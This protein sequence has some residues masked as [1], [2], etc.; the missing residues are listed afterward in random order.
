MPI[1]I[2][3]EDVIELLTVEESIASVEEAFRLHGLGQADNQPRQTPR[4]PNISL[5]VMAGA[6]SEEGLGLKAYTIAREGV[7]SVVLLWNQ[8]T[9]ELQAIIEAGKLGQMRTGAAT[10]VATKYLAR[11][12]ASTVGI[13]GTGR[14]A[15][16]QL[17]AICAV[18]PIERVWVYSPTPEHRRRFADEMSGLLGISVEAAAA[19][20]DVVAEAD[21]VVTITKS[22][23][24]VFDG[25]WLEQGTHINAA[26]SNRVEA[27]EIDAETVRRAGCIAIDDRRQGRSES[28]DLVS[29]VQDGITSWDQVVE[30]GEI[31]SNRATGRSDPRDITLFESLGIAIEDV[32]VARRIYAKAVERG[33]GEALP[34]TRLG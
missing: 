8:E 25:H 30:L 27:R 24:P 11:A 7:R 22:A 14:Q 17:Q 33:A 28:G 34:A 5:H 4:L 13:L 12:D 15:S 32:A 23:Q 10:G 6:I 31:V 19:P 16:S 29:A 18:R 26:G 9:G 3:E 20:R 21:I 2:R 1:L